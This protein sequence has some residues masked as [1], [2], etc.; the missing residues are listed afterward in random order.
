MSSFHFYVFLSRFCLKAGEGIGKA[1]VS[2]FINILTTRSGPQ[3]SKTFQHYAAISDLTL[4]KAL[5]LELKGDI[6]DCLTCPVKCAWNTPAFFAEKLFVPYQG[7]GTRDH[8]LIRILV[9]RSEVDLQKVIEEYR[10]MFDRTLHEDIVNDTKGH[11]QKV[12][13]ALCGPY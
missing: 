12:L 5:Q 4:P 1:N 6:E 3:L 2:T 10:A 11:Y 9:S 13:L 7:H 8:T